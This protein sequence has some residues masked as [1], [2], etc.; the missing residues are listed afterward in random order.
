MNTPIPNEVL[1][2]IGK[3]ALELH[4]ANQMIQEYEKKEQEREKK[5]EEK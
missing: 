2:L 4:I 5:K 3:Q 1:V